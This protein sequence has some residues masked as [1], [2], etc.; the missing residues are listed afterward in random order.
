MIGNLIVRFRKSE[1]SDI[2]EGE[3]TVGLDNESNLD[4]YVNNC[5]EDIVAQISGEGIDN[6]EE[7]LDLE[8]YF[9]EATDEDDNENIE[10][11]L[12]YDWR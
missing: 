5:L 11:D 9:E 8:Y 10:D 2:Y 3:F 6:E 4:E 7:I 1:S 12:S